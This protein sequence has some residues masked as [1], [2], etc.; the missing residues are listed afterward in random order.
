MNDNIKITRSEDFNLFLKSPHI[1]RYYYYF[2]KL[3]QKMLGN[4]K[5]TIR[6][7]VTEQDF[8]DL[9]KARIRMYGQRDD[10]LSSMYR[11]GNTIDD[12]DL[13]AYVFACYL[14]GEII[15]SQRLTPQKFE[16]KQY[17]DNEA[18]VAFLG[19]DYNEHYVEFSRLVADKNSGVKGVANA[20]VMVSAAIV[21]LTTKYNRLISYS[22]PKVD[23]QIKAFSIDNEII[24]FN[25]KE[26]NNNEYILY[27]K[28][29]LDQCRIFFGM[30][31]IK[32]K[33][34]LAILHEKT[35]ENIL[36]I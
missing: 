31:N 9:S 28:D 33:D 30:K 21:I 20:L 6:Q 19:V 1:D 34:V 15:G 23:M 3:I 36:V 7:V 12:R 27:K 32:R 16:V 8:S 18:L 17:I 25:I 35:I 26:R 24:R 2:N 22:R 14:D 29:M 4:D 13:S 5:I 11:N 10:Y